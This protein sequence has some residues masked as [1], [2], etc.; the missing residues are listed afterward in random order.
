MKSNIIHILFVA[1]LLRFVF[2]LVNNYVT[3]LPQGDGDAL[4]TER[5]AYLLSISDYNIDY[6]EYLTKGS[7]FFALICSF[8]YVIFGRQPLVLGLLMVASGVLCVKLIHKASLL[9]FKDVVV[10]KNAAWI[11]ALFPQFCLH[12]AL[13]LREI[14]INLFLLLS[15]IS[16]IKYWKYSKAS[17][18]LPFI[19]FG[20]LAT[21][22][23]SGMFFIFFGLI[24]F[25]VF[26]NKTDKTIK[27]SFAKKYLLPTIIIS[28]IVIFASNGIGLFKFGGSVEGVAEQFNKIQNRVTVGNSAYPQWMLLKGGLSDAW[29]VPI[30]FIAF[31]FAPLLPFMVRSAGHIF[32]LFDAFIYV[33]FFYRM[34]KN[35]HFLKSNTTT[36]AILIISLTLSMVFS[37]G[38]TNTGTGIRHRAKIAPLFILLFIPIQR[39]VLKSKPY[40]F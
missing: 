30:R 35:R 34:Y 10:A 36:S 33:F 12:S 25:N 31:L 4:V 39:K 11:A 26:K 9:L 20:L 2:L 27:V 24:I 32:G 40:R 29:K 8:I 7:S 18:L 19:F 14:P 22:L 21:M 5:K 37:L 15:I 3:Y 1:F 17:S 23:H 38:V 13:V 6:S 16:F 28:A